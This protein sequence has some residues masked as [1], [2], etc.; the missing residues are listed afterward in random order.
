M[1][2]EEAK[3]QCSNSFGIASVIL[4]ILAVNFASVF[5]I[6]PGILGLIFGIKQNKIS[7][8]NWGKWGIILSLIALILSV[9]V[10]VL[11]L[12]LAKN[13]GLFSING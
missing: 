7:R 13:A 5:G 9:L 4:G 12:W 6:V 11:N 1:K 8:N 3:N 2:K 10:I